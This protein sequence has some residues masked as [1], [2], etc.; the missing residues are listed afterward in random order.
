MD[1]YL[2]EIR[3]FAGTYAPVGWHFCDGTLMSVADNNALFSII[4]VTYGGDAISTFQLPDLRG[5]APVSNGS[6]AASAT[7]YQLGAMFGVEQVTLTQSNLP[8]HSHGIM[9][10]TEQ[11]DT[12]S[13]LGS[14]IAV[15]S[16]TGY[17]AYSAEDTVALNPQT[18]GVSPGS[19]A[20]H[21]NMMPFLCISYIIAL[22]GIYPTQD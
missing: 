6:S 4:G 19:G 15:G 7:N 10:S 3:L 21:T 1:N 2:G 11:G 9:V 12:N 16:S 22:T 17:K 8:Q 20:A 14:C 5:R 18:I 13:P